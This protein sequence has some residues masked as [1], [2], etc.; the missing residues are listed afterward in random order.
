MESLKL[1]FNAHKTRFMRVKLMKTDVL[2]QKESTVA[3]RTE[4]FKKSQYIQLTQGMG[5]N[6]V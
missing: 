6:H 2:K 5:P 1:K 3:L 4:K